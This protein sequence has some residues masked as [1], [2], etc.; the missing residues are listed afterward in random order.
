MLQIAVTGG[1]ACGKSLVG[2]ILSTQGASVRDTDD[3]AHRLLA[4]DNEVS[5]QVIAQ[6]GTQILDREG[7][8][9]RATLGEI[10][11]SDDDAREQLNRIVHPTIKAMCTHWL[12]EQEAR[13]GMA[14][15]I[16]PL[17][18]EAG[19][20]GGWD[21]VICVACSRATQ[22]LR[23]KERGL[24][25]QQ[26]EQRMAAQMDVSRKMRMANYVIFND[27]SKSS[28]ETQTRMVMDSILKR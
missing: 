21:A 24:S 22:R 5:Q 17:L 14:V 19:M 20:T 15:L 16:I 27:G 6:F 26:A 25:T 9:D 23:L 8:I 2:D 1:I 3:M 18:Y 4:Q 7:R 13:Q 11:F 28:L 10:V 12:A